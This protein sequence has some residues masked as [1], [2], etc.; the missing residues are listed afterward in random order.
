[1]NSRQRQQAL[2]LFAEMP[3]SQFDSDVIACKA[4]VSSVD[5]RQGQ[6]AV[7]LFAELPS[8]ETNPNVVTFSGE[9]V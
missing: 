8:S 1:M 2:N 4:A 5:S 6:Q 7:S 9:L 3:P